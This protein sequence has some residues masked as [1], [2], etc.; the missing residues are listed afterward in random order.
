MAGERL[1]ATVKWIYLHGLE[2]GETAWRPR[3]DAAR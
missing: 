1:E 2:R 3:D